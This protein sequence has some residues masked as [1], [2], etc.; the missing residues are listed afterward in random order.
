[1]PDSTTTTSYARTR[2]PMLDAPQRSRGRR[3]RALLVS[4]PMF[5]VFAAFG[6]I[7]WLAYVDRPDRPVGEPPLIQADLRPIKVPPNGADARE[8]PAE[9]EVAELFTDRPPAQPE[10]ILP[11][12][13]E[14]ILP[15]EI[16]PPQPAEAPAAV[17]ESAPPADAAPP[18][19]P[20][21]VA[22]I[23]PD[24]GD[25]VAEAAPPPAPPTA[26]QQAATG[27]PPSPPPDERA[28]AE[29]DAALDRLF[30]DLTRPDPAPPAQDGAAAPPVQAQPAPPPAQPAPQ[31]APPAATTE[32]RPAIAPPAA[33]APGQDGVAALPEPGPVLPAPS[34]GEVTGTQPS[35]RIQLAAVREEADARRAWDLFRVD[36]GR[37][38]S[39]VDPIIE[40]A[41]TA[42]GVFYRV[43]VGSFTDPQSAEA[44]CDNLKRQNAS[45]F[46]IRR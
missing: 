24:R 21:A 13:E 20:P 9:G 25:V 23:E 4:L 5:A 38:L 2:R 7:V 22:Q 8:L 45:C 19:E 26:A 16:A 31:P 12:P 30:A 34:P 43:Q 14:P 44:L 29:G 32:V 33:T 46:V 41:E 36:L 40:R 6:S 10:R 1:V 28:I 42:N 3:S 15:G 27:A 11:P 37:Q 17:A 18:A 35:Y 39:G